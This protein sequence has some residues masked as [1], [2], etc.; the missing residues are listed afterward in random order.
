MANRTAVWKKQWTRTNSVS[1][2]ESCF[3]EPRQ[4]AQDSP[5]E[6][7]PITVVQLNE[8]LIRTPERKSRGCLRVGSKDILR[9]PTEAKQTRIDIFTR[10]RRL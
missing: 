3:A 7:E 6:L 10:L 4:R 5:A 8:I 9:L 1:Q 2:A